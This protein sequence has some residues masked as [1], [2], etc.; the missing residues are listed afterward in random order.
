[1]NLQELQETKKT[2]IVKRALKEHYE[3]NMDFDRLTK[4]QAQVMLS[5]VKKLLGEARA[6]KAFYKSHQTGTVLKLVMMEQALNSRL[7][8][9][10]SPSRIVFENEE[11]QKSQVI[12]AAQDMIDSL[13]KMLE[14]ISK[15]NVEELNAVVEGMK[16]EF[17]TAEGDQF[18]QSVGGALSTLQAAVTEAKNAVTGA[19]GTVT[20]EGGGTGEI[21]GA[22]AGMD[23]DGTASAAGMDVTGMD[24]G[25]EM[26]AAPE[27]AEPAPEEPEEPAD[28][29]GA[30]R[31][32]R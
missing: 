13:Q 5:E 18:G 16:N 2:K 1:M 6:N 29:T 11:V 17:G 9:L 12:L 26:G 23:V 24:Q 15:M 19:L 32:R 7:A 25:A 30:G 20:G 3:I 28:T 21:P 27:M 4:I 8:D 31:E 14:D 22:E 10:R